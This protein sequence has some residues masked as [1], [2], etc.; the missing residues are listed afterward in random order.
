MASTPDVGLLGIGVFYDGGYFAEVSDHYRYHHPR[1]ARL[2]IDGIHQFIRHRVA[3]LEDVDL[4]RC[5][6]VDAHY[7]RGR[8]SA[9]E[10]EERGKLMAERQFDDALMRAG[11]I[12]HHLPRSRDGEKGID[13][14]FALEAYE[15][16]LHKRFSVLVMLACDGDYVPLVRKLHSLGTRVML[17]AW[18]VDREMSGGEI[19]VTRTSQRLLEEVT[20]PLVM[21]EM[22]DDPANTGDPLIEGLFV[23]PPRA[24]RTRRRR[25]D[26]EEE[27]RTGRIKFVRHEENWGFIEDDEEVGHDWFFHRDGVLDS[28]FHLL[29]A[30]DIVEFQVGEGRKGPMAVEIARLEDSESVMESQTDSV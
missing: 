6:I 13:V 24:R 19:R 23:V 3:L 10:A 5:Q 2:S 29:E 30:G 17:L 1:S 7:F 26:D 16:A 4:A 9:A 11:V 21:N 12:T 8:F 14:C 28:Q 22:I 27:I 18:E 20:Y 25:L 15:L